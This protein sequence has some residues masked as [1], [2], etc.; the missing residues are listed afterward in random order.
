MMDGVA[1]AG[2]ES[3]GGMTWTRTARA[4]LRRRGG[5]VFA[6]IW[7]RPCPAVGHHRLK[8]KSNKLKINVVITFRLK[9]ML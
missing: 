3:G 6:R 7:W 9:L 1:V 8:R 2:P 4:V 5:R